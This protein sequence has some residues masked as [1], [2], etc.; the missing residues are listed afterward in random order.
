MV[1]PVSGAYEPGRRRWVKLKRDLL[2]RPPPVSRPTAEAGVPV[3]PAAEGAAEL[4][5]RMPDSVDLVVLGSY[6][7]KG[8]NGG[9]QS[10]WLLGVRA[11]DAGSAAGECSSEAGA[12][13]RN[14]ADA[15]PAP[16]SL[17]RW[18]TVAKV[19]NG[20]DEAAAARFNA[21]LPVIRLGADDPLPPWLVVSKGLR[22]HFVVADPATAPVWEV[23]GHG[24]SR[25]TTHTAGVSV[26][27]PRLT[28]ER[29]DKSTNDATTLEELRALLAESVAAKR[30]SS[31]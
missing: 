9:R 5:G 3:V 19:G 17:T 27:F 2:D 11:S 25:S 1:K 12:R 7:G 31:H 28:R 15:A 4:D 10:V 26:R 14:E 29:D 16:P 22:P 8:A 18:V 13:A 6:L 21:T 23:T 20:M 24:L 30:P